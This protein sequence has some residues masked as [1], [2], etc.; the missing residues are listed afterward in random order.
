LL[1]LFALGNFGDCKPVSAGVFE[2]R[3]HF[4]SG[5]R[6]Y[7][8]KDGSTIILLLC[9]GDKNTQN[10]DIKKAKQY[11]KDYQEQKNDKF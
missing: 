11:W 7:Y 5:Y 8:G 6:I 3:L 1:H 9:G 2:F 4:G 10:R